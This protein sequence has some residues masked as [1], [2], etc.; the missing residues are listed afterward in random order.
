VK[1]LVAILA[2]GAIM[3]AT[4]MGGPY[5]VLGTKVVDP[6]VAPAYAQTMV[7]QPTCGPWQQARY[8]S[9]SGWPYFW[10]WR[11]CINY[12]VAPEDQHWY[13]DWAGWEWG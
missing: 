1:R 9:A 7:G 4:M 10:W 8:V 5:T 2:V 12:T 6:V 11:W 3:A 13:V